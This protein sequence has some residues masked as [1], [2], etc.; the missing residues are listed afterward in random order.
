MDT[1]DILDETLLLTGPDAPF[2]KGRPKIDQPLVE[3]LDWSTFNPNVKRPGKPDIEITDESVQDAALRY[4]DHAVCVLNFASGV[5]PGG[6]VRFGAMAQ[7]EALCLASG[8]LHGL[9][10]NPDYYLRNQEDD[11]P[12][13][14]YD[15]ILWSGNVPLIR[16]GEW[17]L[18]EP[19]LIDV[20]TYPA[21]NMHRRAYL[22]DGRHTYTLRDLDWSRAVFRRRCAHVVRLA[23]NLGSE[24]L[25]LGAWGCGEYGNDPYMVAEEFQRAIAAHSGDIAQIVFAIYGGG[26][27]L[28]AFRGVFSQ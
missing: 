24:V 20:I 2:W 3:A 12:D 10:A 15:T 7:E 9:E 18:V 14:C 11:A 1:L 19:M 4:R 13:E 17:N 8:L 21:P 28:N 16:D 6:G 23:A 26:P 5:S 22:G 27:N 25:I